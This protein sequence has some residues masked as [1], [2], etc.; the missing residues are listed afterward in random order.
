MPKP[1][2]KVFKIPKTVI[3]FGQVLQFLS[4][5]LAMKHVFKLFI[6]PH[7]FKRPKREDKM[8]EESKTAM[9]LIPELKKKIKIYSCGFADKKVLLIHG[10]AGRGTQ[11]YK[12][13]ETLNEAGF[14]AVSF[15]ATAHGDSEGKTSTMTEFIPTIL[16]IEK[17]FGPFT[18]AIGHSLGGMALLNAVKDGLKVK[19]ISI[20]GCGNS[21]TGICRQFVKRLELKPKVADLLKNRMDKLLGYDVELLS[22]YI[23]AKSIEISTLVV[24]DTQDDEVPV[25]CAYAI[26]QSLKEGEI[27][28][29]EGLG[30]RRILTDAAVINEILAFLLK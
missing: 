8:Y 24:H 28:I 9:L 30:H 21:V 11:L 27:I 2:P 16:E 23:A 4:P 26:R 1:K 29:T 22:A 12:I 5:V 13:A 7:K 6:T 25:S 17:Q 18:F 19:K 3:Y 10:W 15:D 20:L 14:M